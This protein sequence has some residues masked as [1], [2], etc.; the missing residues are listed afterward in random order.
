MFTGQRLVVTF[1]RLVRKGRFEKAHCMKL[2]YSSVYEMSKRRIGVIGFGQLGK[3]NNHWKLISS[4]VAYAF[5]K[6]TML[7]NQLELEEAG[8]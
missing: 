3:T 4:Q 6:H 2:K 7:E 5:K 1:E 8:L